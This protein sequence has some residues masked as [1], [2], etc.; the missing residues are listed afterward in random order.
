MVAAD[1]KGGRVRDITGAAAT[2]LGSAH[3]TTRVTRGA[4]RAVAAVS[5]LTWLVPDWM[6]SGVAMLFATAGFAGPWRRTVLSN[7]RHVR[8]IDPPSVPVAWY[9]GLR[10]IATLFRTVVSVLRF[11]VRAEGWLDVH[12]GEHL[13][14][15]LGKR[16][17]VVVA[18]HAGPYA[19]LGLLV[20]PWLLSEKFTGP[21]AVVIRM[22]GF[23]GSG[24][25][26][27]WLGRRF[28]GAGVTVV[29]AD[30][31]P[32]QMARALLGTLRANGVV[33]LFVDEPTPDLS[34]PVEFFDGTVSF[35]IGPARLACA[36][37]S[38]I[39]PC[40]AG[41]GS[42]G[43]V[44]MTFA[45]CIE[46]DA[47]PEATLHRI[48]RSLEVLLRTRVDQWAMLTPIWHAEPAS[49][50]G[51]EPRGGRADLHLHTT[52]SDGLCQV[53][54]WV[55][56]MERS[57]V[58][59]IAVT[60]H[61]HLD[62]IRVWKAEAGE[63]GGRVLPGVELTARGRIVHVGVLFPDVVPEVLPK[64]DTPLLE[65]ARWVRTVPGALLVLVH[66]IPFLWKRQLSMLARH[67]LLPDAI[68]VSFP[69]VG[70]R[71]PAI[72]RAAR[73][74]AMAVLGGSDAHLLPGQLGKHCTEFD[75]EFV[76]DLV[77][78]IRTRQT[79]AVSCDAR[80]RPPMKLYA[81][82]TAYSW[83]LPFEHR[84]AVRTLRRRILKWCLGAGRR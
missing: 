76:D 48:G 19:S 68:E 79:R 81:L 7:V 60:D 63:R 31:T 66:P 21:V 53:D 84:P 72:E 71:R 73:Q 15:E 74:Y 77:T 12:G 14:R 5:W 61:D 46:P 38:V 40:I 55:S 62:T 56:E 47:R 80:V 50:S 23:P 18:P 44:D 65:I 51:A 26:R 16:G 24:I 52:G 1:W 9:L 57:G 37:G 39:V 45:E 42:R 36:T 27:N 54:D 70:W 32:M 29:P 10:Q 43:R 78:A 49:S 58:K 28:A 17:V 8:H 34:H 30:L 67:D 22:E 35:P 59:V 41:F 3:T 20:R 4:E 13:T 82:Q 75:G 2:Q 33:V 6:W 69:L 83:L 11:S 64:R 25:I